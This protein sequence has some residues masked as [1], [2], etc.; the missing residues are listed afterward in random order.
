ME[1]E[2]TIGKLTAVLRDTKGK[3]AARR[4]R[5][6]GM[7]PC[8]IYGGGKPTR[9]LAV[10]PDLLLKSLDPQKRRNTVIELTVADPAGAVLEQV[11]LKE[12]QRDPLKDWPLHADFVRIDTQRLVRVRVPLVLEGKA[13]GVKIGGNLHKV[14]RDLE[15]ECTAARIPALI[16]VDVSAMQIGD[17]LPVSKLNVPE[18]V[19]V[20]LPPQQTCVILFAP[21]KIEEEKPVEA[22]AAEGA[23]GAE[24]AAEGKEGAEGGEEGKEGKEGKGKGKD[25]KGK[26]AD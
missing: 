7:I 10:N 5:S 14:F 19:R 26:D 18:G 4:M 9:E 8:V 2:A 21:R 23:E 15:I 22:A 11:M 17:T 6:A 24:G 1:T 20:C 13:E 16:T 25:A 12:L 3:G